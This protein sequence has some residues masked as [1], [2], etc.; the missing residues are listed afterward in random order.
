M[1]RS[2]LFLYILLSFLSGILLHS[3]FNFY[4]IWIW[5]GAVCLMLGSVIVFWRTPHG[6]ASIL[7]GLACFLGLWRT[8]VA[9]NKLHTSFVSGETVFKATGEIRRYP[10]SYQFVGTN[11]QGRFWVIMSFGTPPE[12]GDTV[13]GD[14]RY[15]PVGEADQYY[16]WYAAKGVSTVCFLKNQEV[17][18]SGN[19]LLKKLFGVKQAGLDHINRLFNQSAGALLGGMLFGGT[20]G[21][22]KEAALSFRTAGLTHLV[23]ISGYNF[24]LLAFFIVSLFEFLYVPRRMAS[25][26]TIGLLIIFFI[27]VGPS[28]SAARAVVMSGLII[29][30]K[31]FGRQ[32]NITQIFAVVGAAL[33]AVN[34]LSL[35]YD[36]GFVLSFVATGTLI[37]A[38]PWLLETLE[39]WMRLQTVRGSVLWW[40]T[41]KIIKEFFEIIIASSLIM[42]TTA[43]VIWWFFGRVSLASVVSNA[44]VGPIVPLVMV[45]G[46][47]FAIISFISLP[48]S[49]IFVWSLDLLLKYIIGVA[50]FLS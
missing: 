36:A 43:P 17:I 16:G 46:Y 9:L 35:R 19:H 5:I 30:A 4:S 6:I 15:E 47:L 28:A 48:V 24:S 21:L 27:L 25:G 50:G 23:A 34:P 49:G 12:V 40:P 38:V 20:S 3:F 1:S 41:K 14:C 10:K 44:F 39:K 7:V 32:R 37:Y 2:R 11:E 31:I 8:E 33:L 18:E 42:I 29:A 45:G 26:I 22:S 13:S